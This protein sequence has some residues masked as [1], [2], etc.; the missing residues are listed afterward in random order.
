MQRCPVSKS[1]FAVNQL[2]ISVLNAKKWYAT[3]AI[4]EQIQWTGSFVAL[5][6]NG[7]VPASTRHAMSA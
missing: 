6:Q 2:K 4:A 7:G 5:T 1:V 3:I